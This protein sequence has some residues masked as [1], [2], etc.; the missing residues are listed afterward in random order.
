M[1]YRQSVTGCLLEGEV[2]SRQLEPSFKHLPEGVEATGE[3]SS[4]SP[5]TCSTRF[6]SMTLH[7]KEGIYCIWI[8]FLS[9][10]LRKT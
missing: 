9:W 7:K 4:T 1:N 10:S 5:D 3:T 8:C 2:G 6:R